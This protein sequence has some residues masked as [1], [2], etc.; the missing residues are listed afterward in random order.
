MSAHK[1]GNLRLGANV[2]ELLLPHRRPLLLVDFIDHFED[3]DEPSLRAGKHVSAGDAVFD[4][5][6]PALY[7]WPGIYVIEGLGQSCHLLSVLLEIRRGLAE[8]GADPDQVL[9]TLRNLDLGY[10]LH[11]GFK[12]EI[13]EEM[14]E[15]FGLV[16]LHLGLASSVDIKF[17][18]PVFAGQRLDYAVRITHRLDNMVR[19]GVEARVEGQIVAKGTTTASQGHLVPDVFHALVR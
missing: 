12:P 13:P 1:K 5:H 10:R 8:Q 17:V 2:V 15:A 18:K 19:C 16:G 6:F 3:G 14:V 9:E 11:P 7:L 4:G